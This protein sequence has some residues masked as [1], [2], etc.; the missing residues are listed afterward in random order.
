[1]KRNM[2]AT[3]LFLSLGIYIWNNFNIFSIGLAI[4]IVAIYC[5]WCLKNRN[6]LAVAICIISVICGFVA[7]NVS[8]SKAM[9]EAKLFD[10]KEVKSIDDVNEIKDK[11]SVG[12]KIDIVV[13][14]N[15][16][17]VNLTITLQ[18]EKP[19]ENTE[20]TK[21]QQNKVQGEQYQFPSDFFSWFGW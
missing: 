5:I 17:K 20:T 12:D 15:G 2:L 10:G 8:S 18:E 11:H 9:Q 21:P 1:M 19:M 4:C 7:I 14:R 6:F 13:S 3:A 16:A